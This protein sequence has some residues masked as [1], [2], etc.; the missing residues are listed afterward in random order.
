MLLKFNGRLK[1]GSIV[2]HIWQQQTSCNPAE[3][4]QH[5]LHSP[6]HDMWMCVKYR[7]GFRGPRMTYSQRLT[8][9]PARISSDRYTAVPGYAVSG[10]QCTQLEVD[11]VWSEWSLSEWKQ[12]VHANLSE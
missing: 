6:Q 5:S 10:H 2:F 8:Q 7:V 1:R 12:C 4:A 3:F 11:S 9:A